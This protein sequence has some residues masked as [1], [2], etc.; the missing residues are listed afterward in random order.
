[1]TRRKTGTVV[2]GACL[3]LTLAACGSEDASS[4]VAADC[5]PAHEFE[6]VEE[7]TLTVALVDL[8]PYAS[9]AGDGFEGVDAEI[10]EAFAERECLT[11]TPKT[12]TSASIIP[13]IQQGQ[14]DLSI[15]DWYRTSARAEVVN[16]SDPLYLDDMGVIST[17][18]LSTIADLE[19]KKVGT[20]EGYLWVE[21]LKAVLGD[22]LQLY[23]TAVNLKQ[24]IDAGRVD[25][26]VDSY[27]SAVQQFGDDFTIEVAEPDPRVAASEEAAQAGLPIAKDNTALLDAVNEVLAELHEDGTIAQILTDHGL[28]PSSAETGEPRLI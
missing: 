3:T 2:L 11:V 26:G 7:G 6:T 1:M 9:T 19:G 8:P 27:G 15:G 23:P 5:T 24:D 14:A 10:V 17:D 12:G 4:T 16:L 20:V 13:T 21:D 25:V 22:D 18:G 28:D